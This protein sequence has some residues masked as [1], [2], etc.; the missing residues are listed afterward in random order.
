[1]ENENASM[2]HRSRKTNEQET[3]EKALNFTSNQWKCK[4]NNNGKPFEA[5]LISEIWSFITSS[6]GEDGAKLPTPVKLRNLGEITLQNV[7]T[8]EMCLSSGAAIPLLSIYTRGALAC[9]H[10]TT[11]MRRILRALLVMQETLGVTHSTAS[12]A[13]EIVQ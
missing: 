2:I 8:F 11:G 13:G 1:M 6:V 4:L 12:P 10:K 3:H 9:V 5:H 7:F